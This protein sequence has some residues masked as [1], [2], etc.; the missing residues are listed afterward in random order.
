MS[1]TIRDV[2][3]LAQVSPAT[4]SRYFSGSTVVGAELSKKIEAAAGQLGYV[5]VRTT[6]RNQG[7][8]I[9]L[10]PHLKLGVFQRG[11][12]GDH[13]ADAQIQMQGRHPAHH[14]GR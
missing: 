14:P 8:I 5:P 12:Q 4:V 10:L 7:T 11:A 2:A 9:V 13:P 1:A 6:K 3:K